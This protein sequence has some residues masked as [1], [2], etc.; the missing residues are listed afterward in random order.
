MISQQLKTDIQGILQ[1]ILKHN[2]NMEL[3]DGTLCKNRFVFYL[4]QD[5]FYLTEYAKALAITASR[6]HAHSD[7]K[8][9]LQ[10]ALEA[11]DDEQAL[12]TKYLGRF[13]SIIQDLN[14]KEPSPTCF[15]YTNFLIQT[16]STKPVE[17]SIAALL[18][19][20]YIYQ[21]LAQHMQKQLRD[22][23]GHPYGEWITLYASDDFQLSTDMAFT[24]LD[25]LMIDSKSHAD[26]KKTFVYSSKLEWM[27]WQSA[28]K[29]EAWPNIG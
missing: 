2:F 6:L 14:V 13:K 23:N 24:T 26:V 20:F 21:Q 9:F 11:I 27:F 25:N 3:L 8:T 12:H 1:V 19:C 5:K 15:M 16:A 7:M 18:P 17:Q 29:Y 4:L 22:I 28:Y 10:F